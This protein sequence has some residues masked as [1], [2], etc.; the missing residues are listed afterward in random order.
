MQCGATVLKKR[1]KTMTKR[2]YAKRSK[3]VHTKNSEETH[4]AVAAGDEPGQLARI[5]ADPSKRPKGGVGV[6][7]RYCGHD[8]MFIADVIEVGGACVVVANERIDNCLIRPATDEATH[9]LVDF[10]KAGYWHP[11]KGIFVVPS[12]QVHLL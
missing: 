3:R 9:H 7:V 12:D 2:P 10:P 8:A 1:S 5:M 4:A 6:M 11:H